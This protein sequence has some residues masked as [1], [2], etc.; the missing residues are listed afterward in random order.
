MVATASFGKLR[1]ITVTPRIGKDTVRFVTNVLRNGTFL[2]RC[3]TD[4]YVS[5]RF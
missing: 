2:L 4:S 3:N 5:A 1:T